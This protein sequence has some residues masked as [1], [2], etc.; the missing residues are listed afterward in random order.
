MANRIDEEINVADPNDPASQ[1][2]EYVKLKATESVLKA[3]AEELRVTIFARMEEAG[4][5]DDKGNIQ[6]DLDQ[7][8]DGVVRLEKQRR[9]TRKLNEPKAEEILTALGIYDEVFVMKPV[10][11]E[12]AL[13]AAY[14]E[15]KIT[16]EQLDEM[17]PTNVVWALRVLKK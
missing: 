9:A 6:L 3:R 13:M 7:P 5:E 1:I 11:D 4:Y 15:N 10:L 16:E 14:F 8:V 17:F 2:R 12:D